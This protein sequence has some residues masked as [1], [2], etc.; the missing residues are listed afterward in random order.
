MQGKTLRSG[1]RKAV[2]GEKRLL[3]KIELHFSPVENLS[4]N[5][6]VLGDNGLKETPQGRSLRKIAEK[7]CAKIFEIINL[8]NL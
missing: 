1:K 4:S 5:R 8:G 2:M 3:L 7:C 6:D